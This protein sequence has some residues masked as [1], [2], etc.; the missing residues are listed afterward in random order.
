MD[1]RS[2]VRIRN[3]YST[4]KKAVNTHSRTRRAVPYREAIDATLSNITEKTL[5][6]ITSA[7]ILVVFTLVNVS[8]IVVKRRTGA[9]PSGRGV[10]LVVPC[11]GAGLCIMFLGIEAWKQVSA[12]IAD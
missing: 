8:L 7:I 11:M 2:T 4:V 9:A 10:P 12:L 3:T 1:G 5:A 6:K